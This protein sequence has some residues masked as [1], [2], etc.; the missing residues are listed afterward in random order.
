M[1]NK[2]QI[3]DYFYTREDGAEA[4]NDAMKQGEHSTTQSHAGRQYGIEDVCE[5]LRRIGRIE[6]ELS[7]LSE[8]LNEIVCSIAQE[9]QSTL[10]NQSRS[11]QPLHRGDSRRR[12]L[13][14]IWRGRVE[15]EILN[16]Q[17]TFS[18]PLETP[19]RQSV[20]AEL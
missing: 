1:N 16:P 12:T 11:S 4:L 5:L 17:R 18:E 10:H 2:R 7:V 13:D 20:L 3:N 9:R 14:K 19:S 8:E 15:Q 6:N